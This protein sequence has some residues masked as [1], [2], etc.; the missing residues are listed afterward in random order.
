[1]ARQIH[2]ASQVRVKEKFKRKQIRKNLVMTIDCLRDI[3]TLNLSLASFGVIDERV[4]N[5]RQTL[6]GVLGEVEQR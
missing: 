6:E 4:R 3:E 5:A 2:A 1:M